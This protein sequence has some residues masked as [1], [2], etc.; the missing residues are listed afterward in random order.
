[1]VAVFRLTANC[2]STGETKRLVSAFSLQILDSIAYGVVW[3][4]Y[5]LQMSLKEYLATSVLQIDTPFY[6]VCLLLQE[7]LVQQQQK[8]IN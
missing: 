2:S 6:D 4:H 1:M 5:F 8:G 3:L 7:E